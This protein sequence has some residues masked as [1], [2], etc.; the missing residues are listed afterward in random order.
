MTKSS[1]RW[2]LLV[3]LVAQAPRAYAYLDPGSVSMVLQMIVG[4]LAGLALILKLY[5]RKLLG[6]FGIKK[7]ENDQPSS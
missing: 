1:F 4:G 7:H 5:W 6:L 3:L 2:A